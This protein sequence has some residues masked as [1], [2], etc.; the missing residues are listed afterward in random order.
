MCKI[1]AVCR[2]YS[3][4]V[5]QVS[6][7]GHISGFPLINSPKNLT[8]PHLNFHTH[9]PCSFLY[10]CLYVP[11]SLSLE[12]STSV[13]YQHTFF[14]TLNSFNTNIFKC[15]VILFTC[16]SHRIYCPLP[17]SYD[18]LFGQNVSFLLYADGCE[19]SISRSFLTDFQKNYLDKHSQALSSSKR[20]I[21]SHIFPPPTFLCCIPYI[22][23]WNLSRYSLEFGKSVQV[24]KLTKFLYPH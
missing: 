11:S 3:G 12:S 17:S 23:D 1:A 4:M 20:L 9:K 14:L 22:S 24:L 10:P 13:L 8:G 6:V 18:S 5:C 2:V 21:C 19:L 7:S 15:A 16:T